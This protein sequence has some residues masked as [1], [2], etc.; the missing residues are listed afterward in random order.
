MTIRQAMAIVYKIRNIENENF[1]VGS[2]IN[3]NKRLSKHLF[4]LRKNI[5]N[6][7]HLQRAY[8]KYGEDK[9][10]I[11]ILE[12]CNKDNI[13][14]REQYYIDTLK[15]EYNI[16]KIAYSTIGVIPSKET[17]LKMSKAHKD[18]KHTQ[19]SKEK[20]SRIHLGKKLSNGHKLAISNGMKKQVL[21]FDKQGNFIKEWNSVV[22]ATKIYSNVSPVLKGK[23]KT[24]GGFIWKYKNN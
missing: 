22:E 13:I 23:R 4:E 10:T 19:E 5:H 3:V 8:N 17:R 18:I 9:F 11:E 2:S 16:C 21:Q 20:M 15:P 1:Y 14:E 6:N 24:A 7:L 12:F